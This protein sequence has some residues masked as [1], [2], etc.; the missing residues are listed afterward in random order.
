MR[1]QLKLGQ[2]TRRPTP[3]QGIRPAL[4][5]G[6]FAVLF[7]TNVTMGV[8]MMM[9]GDI[10]RL[11]NG[12][13]EDVLSAYEDRI[14]ELRLEVDRLNSRSY[15][16]TGDMNLQMQELAQ[17]Q[18]LLLEQHQLVKALADRAGELG[19][20]TGSL[21]HDPDQGGDS[22]A[23]PSPA[24][25]PTAANLHQ[26]NQ[27]LRGMI[28]DSRLAMAAIGKVA[29]SSTSEILDELRRIGITPELPDGQAAV[30][31]PLLPA[32]DGADDSDLVD[33][34]NAVMAS[35]NRLKAA[36]TAID[37]APVHKPM[38]GP[39][40]M[41][42][43]F[44]NRRDPFT[45]S[46]AF[47]AGLD[48]SAPMGTTVLS[49]GQGTIS[50][51]GQR[52]GYGNVVEVTHDGGVMTRYGHLSATL[53]REGQHVQTGTPIARV[54]STGRSTGPHLHFEVR[55]DDKAIDPAGFLAVGARLQRYLAVS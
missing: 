52:S 43:G 13:N 24:V 50:F 51:V 39:L 3:R 1:S 33:D 16:Q 38:T 15:A 44:G 23:L 55:R 6:M 8:G 25:S 2:P 40:R 53:V 12:Q 29:T 27:A 48:F 9:S 28:E 20:G 36:R 21:P 26:Q 42:S 46:S 7:G 4:F 10:A 31:G 17:Q 14:A 19:I 37:D 54:G 41:S 32:V 22:A 34:A 47:H 5:Y 49:A 35:L 18:D 30:G 11:L 45:G